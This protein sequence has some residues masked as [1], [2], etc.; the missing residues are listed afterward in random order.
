MKRNSLYSR[1]SIVLALAIALAGC[2][3]APS[4]DTPSPDTKAETKSVPK[5]PV[6]SAASQKR[7]SSRPGNL[8][9]TVFVAEYHNFKVGKG[10]FFRT[11]EQFQS[12]LERFYSMGFRPVLASEYLANKMPLPPGASPVVIT[13]DDSSPTQLQLM[14]DGSVDPNCAVGIWQEFAKT[15]LDFPVHGTF[16][17]LPDTLWARK[18]NDDRKVKL[19]YSLG[20]ELANHT[21][22]HPIL[23]HL[24]DDKVKWEL[25]TANE[26]LEALG[27]PLPGPMALPFGVSPKHVSILHGFDWNG[28]HVVFTGVFLNGAEPAKSPNNPKFNRFRVPRIIATTV[29]YGLDFWLDKLKAGKVKPYVQP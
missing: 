13:L 6:A 23:S 8:G 29:P 7:V 27:Q 21:M 17:V 11:K 25:G 10:D 22:T 24:T 15:H 5:D 19:I 28:K 14:P 3:K 2:S 26:K 9:G 16:F 20:N 12:D 18:S 1:L 4:A